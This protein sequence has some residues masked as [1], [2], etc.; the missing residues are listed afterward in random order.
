VSSISRTAA[1][2]RGLYAVTPEGL[3]TAELI[4]RVASALKGGASIVQYRSKS[5]NAERRLCEAREL[6]ALCA[7]FE[8]VFIVNDDIDLALAVDADGVHLGKDDGDPAL[9]RKRLQGRLLGA[10]CYDDWQRADSAVRSGADYVAF[11]SFFPSR[12]KPLAVRADPSL[13]IRAKAELGVPVV[14]IG[15]VDPE[16]AAL[17]VTAGADAVAVV[18]ALFDAEDVEAQAQ[19]FASLFPKHQPQPQSETA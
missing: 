2:L 4:S 9:A 5:S 8:A 17:L 18:S 14:A 15:G 1:A 10:S 3:P 16:N 19:R 12:I 6:R 11:G 7:H 13:L